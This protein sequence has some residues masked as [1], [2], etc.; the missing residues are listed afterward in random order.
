MILHSSKE[1]SIVRFFV[2]T[3]NLEEIKKAN[4][5]VD[6]VK[7]DRDNFRNYDGLFSIREHDDTIAL[8][9][10]IKNR[11]SQKYTYTDKIN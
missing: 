10:R 5:V 3:A 6:M 4:D 9:K 2:D 1:E 8:Q 11:I 7:V